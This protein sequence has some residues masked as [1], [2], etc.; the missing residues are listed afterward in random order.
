MPEETFEREKICYEQNFEQARSLN[1]QMNNIPTLSITLTSG[2]WFGAALTQ[3]VDAVIRFGLLLLAGIYDLVLILILFR[4]RD[5][6]ESYLEKIEAFDKK[7]FAS[8]KPL[9]PK[10]GQFGVYS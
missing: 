8:G 2:L 1:Q 9:K 6:L 10:L 5:V 3:N 4:V 7:N